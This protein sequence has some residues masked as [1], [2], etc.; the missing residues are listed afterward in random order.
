MIN[1]P[2]VALAMDLVSRPSVTPF[3][4]GCQD[5]MIDRL[6]SCGFKVERLQFDDVDN[7][8][9]IHG[10]DGPI[11]CFAGHTDVV[12]TG[13]LDQWTNP[14]FFPEIKDGLL[15]GRGAA[16]MKGSLAAM[17]VAAEQFVTEYPD[18]PGRLA[19]LITSDEEGVAINGTARVVEWLQEQQIK[20]QW[21]LVGEP[22]SSE[23]CGDTIKNGRRG[24]LGC[25][26][27]ITGLQGHVAY[28]HL[29][30]NPIHLAT[31]AINELIAEVWDEGNQYFPPT[32]FQISNIASGTG[33]TNVIPGD[34]QI[35][36]NI[37]FSTEV[38]DS[39]L[40][41]R[42]E[43]I[44]DK[45]GL[46]Y[47]MEWRLSGRP[48]LTKTGLLV[49]VATECIQLVTGLKTVLSTAGGTSDGRF[50][51]PMGS[52]VLELGPLNK[53]IHR[54]DEHVSADDL[55]KLTEIYQK[56]VSHLLC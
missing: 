13:P 19:F 22:S 9:A 40:R 8:W 4:A 56:I 47:N 51:A 26:M 20:P 41:Q 18:H 31:P 35:M 28:P 1:S 45:H 21:C 43:D 14:P 25:C 32:S 27:T 36:F 54:V 7:F 34:I 33:A 50:I 53:S 6:E 49:D 30:S 17:V 55:N 38:T 2:T 24:S 46:N 39:Q 12:P 3:D 10:S 48:F 42:V 44:L 37:R 11:F 16:D 23:E 15:F 5:L 52:E 29:A